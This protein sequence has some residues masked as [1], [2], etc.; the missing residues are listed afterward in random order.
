[1]RIDFFLFILMSYVDLT[2]IHPER[3]K[4]ELICEEKA[5]TVINLIKP[6]Q[7]EI[8]PKTQTQ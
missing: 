4:F 8:K 1:M 7:S 3:D 2:T 5:R 6:N